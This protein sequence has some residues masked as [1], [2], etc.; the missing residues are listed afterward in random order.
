MISRQHGDTGQRS[1]LECAHCVRTAQ[2]R[3]PYAKVLLVHHFA[4]VPDATYH[5]NSYTSVHLC[6]QAV[7]GL[8]LP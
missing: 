3:L 6:V 2:Y 5:I 1:S 7:V 8:T 4:E